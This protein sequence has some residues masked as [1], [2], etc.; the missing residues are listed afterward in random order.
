[1]YAY[2]NTIEGPGGRK[3]NTFSKQGLEWM[4]IYLDVI[5]WWGF[6]GDCNYCM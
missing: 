1:V 3:I 6:K 2:D 4:C 5:G